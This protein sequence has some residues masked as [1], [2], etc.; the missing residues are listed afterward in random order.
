MI[1]SLFISFVISL[2]C[3]FNFNFLRFLKESFLIFNVISNSA[4]NNIYCRCFCFN[5]LEVDGSALSNDIG[6]QSV[7]FS[8]AY[9]IIHRRSLAG[10]HTTLG[11]IL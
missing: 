7:Y 10:S 11:K 1:T 2:F 3:L 9:C 6:N 8:W 4:S 5:F